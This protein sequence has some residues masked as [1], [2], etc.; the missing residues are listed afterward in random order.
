MPTDVK[1][2]H[3]MTPDVYSRSGLMYNYDQHPKGAE[4][5]DY[6]FSLLPLQQFT[7][8]I[9][10]SSHSPRILD[11]ASGV[12]LESYYL[13]THFP[14]AEI[15]SLDI[16]NAGTKSGKE[17][18]GLTQ[19]QADINQPPFPDNSFD[20]IHCKDVLVHVPDKKIFM[21]N[22]ARLLKPNGVLVLSSAKTAYTGFRQFGWN[23]EK[24]T[25]IAVDRGLQLVLAENIE[26]R[27]EDWYSATGTTR[28]FMIF[29]KVPISK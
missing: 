24:L 9:Q 7:A 27:K 25:K 1:N 4:F 18:Y 12:G 11:L 3:Q 28:V 16:S 17:I 6:Y 14:T 21:D 8:E 15:I 29:R 19:V 13:K 2:D 10:K 20:G 26:M 22:V 23:Q 5:L